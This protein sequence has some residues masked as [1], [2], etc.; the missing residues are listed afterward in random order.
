[1]IQ[2]ALRHNSYLDVA[3]YFH[4]VWETPVIKD[5][6]EGRGREVRPT[7]LPPYQK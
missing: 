6:T 2:F 4:K 7:L 3:K 1:M 5:E